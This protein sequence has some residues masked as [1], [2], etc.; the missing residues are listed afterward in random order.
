MRVSAFLSFIQVP[1]RYV[2]GCV[3]VAKCNAGTQQMGGAWVPTGWLAGGIQVT[4]GYTRV[5]SALC[6]GGIQVATGWHPAEALSRMSRA[7]QG[8]AG[9]GR[10]GV[11]KKG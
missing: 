9:Q 7:G 2:C 6:L 1:I 3:W 4:A 5:A 8:R 11:G 10:A